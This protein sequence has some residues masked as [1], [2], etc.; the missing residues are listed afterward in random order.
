M[1]RTGFPVAL[2]ATLPTRTAW[3]LAS[4]SSSACTRFLFRT[5]H[6]ITL[7][8]CHFCV[9]HI[10]VTPLWACLLIRDPLLTQSL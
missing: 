5:I 10:T 1:L 2:T 4:V 9:V 6:L 7:I 8:V 3:P